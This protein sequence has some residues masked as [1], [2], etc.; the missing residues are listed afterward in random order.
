[1]L[2][3]AALAVAL[4]AVGAAAGDSEPVCAEGSNECVATPGSAMLQTVKKELPKVPVAEESHAVELSVE[5]EQEAKDLEAKAEKG[6]LPDLET[7]LAAVETDA[8]IVCHNTMHNRRICALWAER[9]RWCDAGGWHQK[10]CLRRCA[11]T[12]MEV[13]NMDCWTLRQTFK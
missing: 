9:K 4:L 1:M 7:P 6:L 13:L 10:L 8:S 11:G 12:C 2:R 5:E 3:T